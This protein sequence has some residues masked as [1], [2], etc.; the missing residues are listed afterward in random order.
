LPPPRIG[1]LM[2][3]AQRSRRLRSAMAPT[4]P[5]PESAVI[6]ATRSDEAVAEWAGLAPVPCTASL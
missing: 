6:V 2:C 5:G 1:S 3:P 4:M